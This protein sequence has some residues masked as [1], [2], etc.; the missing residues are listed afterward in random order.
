MQLMSNDVTV[1]SSRSIFCPVRMQ[2]SIAFDILFEIKI[3]LQ[4]FGIMNG[5]G[6]QKKG[7]KT[8]IR[9]EPRSHDQIV[10]I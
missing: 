3:G 8:E 1:S 10:Q 4:A 9:T 7:I 2:S 6:R 5:M